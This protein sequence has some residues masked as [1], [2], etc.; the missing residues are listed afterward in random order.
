M[1]VR[2][3]PQPRRLGIALATE[4]TRGRVA[5]RVPT[6]SFKVRIWAS[7]TS[8]IGHRLSLVSGADGNAECVRDVTHGR[9]TMW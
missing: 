5:E 3:R 1:E 4:V 8:G 9:L 7:R 6:D 2:A